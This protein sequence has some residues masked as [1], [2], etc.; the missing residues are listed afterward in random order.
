MNFDNS[1]LDIKEN[2]FLWR[3]YR[4]SFVLDGKPIEKPKNLCRYFWTSMR[5]VTLWLGREVKLWK[6]WGIFVLSFLVFTLAGI[7]VTDD[8]FKSHNII[9][10]ILALILALGFTIPLMLATY[11]SVKRFINWAFKKPRVESIAVIVFLA[12]IA[13]FTWIQREAALSELIKT[14]NQA[15]SLL[16]YGIA[17]AFFSIL[18]AFLFSKLFPNNSA[19]RLVKTFTVYIQAKKKRVCPPVK[20]PPSFQ[21][22]SEED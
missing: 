4:K 19:G 14:F 7:F 20:E 5:G 2:D 22:D 9:A 16:P 11:V 3:F 8:F 12:F 15:V 17:L 13:I 18:F 6:L 21:E 1:G 10:N